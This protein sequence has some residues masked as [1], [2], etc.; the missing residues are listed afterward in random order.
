M[1][2]MGGRLAQIPLIKPKGRI[3]RRVTYHDPCHLRRAQ[4]IWEEP[5]K[6]LEMIDGLDFVELPESNWCCG[7]AGSQLITHP[8][9]S[10]KVLRRKMENAESTGAQVIASGCP[11]C[12]MQ[13]HVGV[14]RHGLDVE[15]VHPVVLLDRAYRQGESEKETGAK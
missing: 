6:L 3:D 5:R 1:A 14:R 12:Q 15:V 7:S 10:L 8:E 13:L 11:G 9:T 2:D 4:R